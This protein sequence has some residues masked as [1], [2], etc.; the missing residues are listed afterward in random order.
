MDANRPED[1]VS[2]VI[3]EARALAA[4]PSMRGGP[5][6]AGV[7]P[8]AAPAPREGPRAARRLRT[9]NGVFSTPVIGADETV[10]VGS[11]DRAFY[12]WD[13]L[14]D[15]L[16]WRFETGEVIDSAAAI[17]RDGAIYVA[18]GDAR[19]YALDPASGRERWRID[20]FRDRRG[21]TPSPIHWFEGNIA[22][23]PEGL[24]FAGCDDFYLYAIEPGGRVRWAAPTGLHIWTAPAFTDDGAVVVVSFDLFAYCFE[25]ASGRLRWR[26]RVGNFC[27]SSPAIDEHGRIW[28]GD[29]AGDLVAL[30]PARGREVARLGLGA[31][32]YASPALAPDGRLYVGAAD[33][34][35]SAIDRASLRVLWT[36]DAGDP[37]RSSAAIGP[38]P[39]A[40]APYLVYVGGGDGTI[41]AFEPGG[42]R[43]WAYD[44]LAR[45]ASRDYP[46][47]NASIA[48]GRAGLATGTAG[49]DVVYLPYDLYL[50]APDD[51]AISRREDDGF[52]RDA[53]VLVAVSSGG[54]PGR[55]LGSREAPLEGGEVSAGAALGVR[56]LLRRDGASVPASIRE[57][58]L[59][60]ATAPAVPL[61]AV[62]LSEGAQGC[63]VPETLLPPGPVRLDVEAVLDAASGPIPVAGSIVVAPR[64]A[65][66]ARLAEGSA[67][68]VAQMAVHTP[69][70][71]PSFDQIG[72]ASLAIDVRV[73]RVD[74]ASGRIAAFGLM[75]FGTDERGERVAVT[76]P[77]HLFYAFGGRCRDGHVVL[78]AENARFET[79]AEQVPLDR[80]RLAATLDARGLPDLGASLVAELRFP[81]ALAFFAKLARRPG[82]GRAG[83]APT[84]ARWARAL[85]APGAIGK[86][87]ATLRFAPRTAPLAVALLRGELHRPWRL[88]DGRGRFTG[89]GTFRARPARPEILEMPPGARVAGFAYDRRRRRLALELAGAPAT[90]VP[91][92][93][94]IDRETGAPLPLDYTAE[95]AIER[96]PRGEPRRATLELPRAAA[97]RP[98]EAV[99]LVDLAIAGR[100]ELPR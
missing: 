60:V 9:G 45:A 28:F 19:V 93:L 5:R 41:H 80:L 59:R 23:G 29:F 14:R 8:A 94:A 90:A 72:I 35:F 2:S 58:S 97:R 48:L 61:R 21:F 96:G 39:E 22:E 77:R 54:R 69:S 52:P 81:G 25:A 85:A 27:A 71:V 62:A 32:I 24:L 74:A 44:T 88:V 83:L 3:E 33:G 50:A 87:A 46:N 79:T 98:L 36:F 65:A 6:N 89:V 43:R 10:Y 73:L 64:A 70:I 66:G 91:A 31:S 82:S 75:K 42:R 56:A 40:R 67:F 34:R 1:I 38:D 18:S 55:A 11:A 20:V 99:A 78:E 4:W 68:R 37:I 51:P 84:L 17:G 26:T 49:G 15:A 95:V 16:R 92:I 13:P 47:V 57:G 86:L 76:A 7:G 30:E 100:L 12:A 53:A 63:L